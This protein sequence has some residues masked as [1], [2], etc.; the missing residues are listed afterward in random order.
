MRFGPSGVHR[1]GFFV[2]LELQMTAENYKKS[3]EH[4][5]QNTL[6]K[7]N[8]EIEKDILR[9]KKDVES[10]REERG[11]IPFK[12]YFVNK[13]KDRI[14]EATGGIVA[15]E[16]LDL[17]FIDR[18]QFG[19]DIAIKVPKFLK[20]GG[21]KRYTAEVVPKLVAGLQ[22]LTGGDQK[23]ADNVEHKGI[24]VNVLLTNQY[25]F[26]NVWQAEKLGDRFGESDIYKKKAVVVDYSSPN[27]A[28]HLHAGHIRSTIIGEV[29]SDLYQTVGYTSHRLN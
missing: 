21:N 2:I 15:L 26:E 16:D 19:G 13:L 10:R 7:L 28:K 17:S 25:L 23:I 22:A 6:E 4:M 14:A 18:Q 3:I 20:E 24:Y 5:K 9:R 8:S 29:L 1:R 11:Y 27:V 12:E